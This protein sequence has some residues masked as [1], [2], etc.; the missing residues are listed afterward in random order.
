MLF[1]SALAGSCMI[2]NAPGSLSDI[3]SEA[4]RALV[5]SIWSI[6]PMNGPVTGPLIGGF[7]YQYL[8]WRWT[9]WLV[10]IFSGAAL[11]LVTCVRETYA[12]AILKRKAA[13]MRASTGDDRYWS[14]YDVRTA[15]W[16]TL[17]VNLT[18]PFVMA[19]TE[20]I[21][22]FWNL[23]ISV[24]YGILYLCFVAY[25]YIFSGIRG[26]SPGI[27][28]LAFIG[29][30]TGTM[31][32]IMSEPLI[33]K[34][35]NA[36]K[37]DPNTGRVPPEASIS[38][39]CIAACLVPTGQ[40]IF[41]WTSAPAS[42]HWIWSILAGVPFGAGNCLVFI[43]SSSYLAGSYGIYAAS[44]LA[45]NAVIRSFVGGTLPLAGPA[46]Y[47]AMS[48]QW[49]GTFLGLLEV[50]LIPIPFV[51]YK[52][53]HRIRAASPLIKSMREEQDRLE[54]KQA[55]RAGR[56]DVQAAAEADPEKEAVQEVPAKEDDK[57]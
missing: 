55:R 42:I 20:P 34:M 41:S 36:H 6:G 14:R 21:L 53:G 3:S 15:F 7:T 50:A 44:A 39:V 52:Y 43:Y 46:M 37:K 45:G 54:R 17:R 49:A 11:L 51:F 27:S 40:L 28:G 48:P 4:T 23:Y 2:S 19:L 16:E 9:N 24:I 22:W 25:P 5:F 33:R 35:I 1:H 31:F 30:G 8:G 47:K 26:W 38:V 57:I 29:V 32:G 18:R 56:N 10:L 13:A 12:P